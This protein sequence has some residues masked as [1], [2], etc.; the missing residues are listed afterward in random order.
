[1]N[2]AEYL[3]FVYMLRCVDGSLY[4]GITTDLQ[5]RLDQH[6]QGTGAKYTRSRRPVS[7]LYSQSC[8]S[9]SEAL[10]REHAIKRMSSKDKWTLIEQSNASDSSDP[11]GAVK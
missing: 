11:S 5:R 1:M 2:N 4:T 10:K 3:W 6:N 8:C 7:L 9:Q